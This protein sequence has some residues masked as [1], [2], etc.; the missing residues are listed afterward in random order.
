[1]ADLIIILILLGAAALAI[2]S[3]MRKSKDGGCPGGCSGCGGN[4]GCNKKD[5]K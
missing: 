4:C 5:Q 1:M 3:C 2:R